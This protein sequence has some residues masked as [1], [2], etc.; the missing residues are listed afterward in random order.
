MKTKVCLGFPLSSFFIQFYCVRDKQT[1]HAK[2][3]RENWSKGMGGPISV[4]RSCIL[5]STLLFGELDFILLLL[6]FVYFFL[7]WFLAKYLLSF[8][9]S[10]CFSFCFL[11]LSFIWV[12]FAS[13]CLLITCVC[14][15]VCV[16]Y[17]LFF[18][19]VL[20]VE[21]VWHKSW[22]FSWN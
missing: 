17:G 21:H 5:K 19:C 13:F 8:F 11:P 4:Y 12:F 15:T 2:E 22:A 20:C 18:M 16:C 3:C 10:L 14:V 9:S 7:L 6:F 1:Q